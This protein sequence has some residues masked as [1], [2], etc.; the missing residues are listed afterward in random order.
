ML[1]DVAEHQELENQLSGMLIE[2]VGENP[3]FR[4][5]GMHLFL[6]HCPSNT[7]QLGF[8]VPLLQVILSRVFPPHPVCLQAALPGAA[9]H[10][11]YP[12]VEAVQ[13]Q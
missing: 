6:S 12:Q 10:E 8:Q 2:S 7:C 3:P 4:G 9:V 5:A 13:I 1:D 11:H